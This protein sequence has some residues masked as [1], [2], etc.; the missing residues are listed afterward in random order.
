MEKWFEASWTSILAIF[1]TAGGIYMAII[2]FT[3]I[4]GKRSFSK[5][6]SFDFA[7]TVAVGSILATTI[8]SASVSLIHGIVGLAAVYI[9]QISA[10]ILRRFSWFQ[11]A[12]DNSPLLL[13]DGKKILHENLKKARVTEG[14][15]RSKLRE[16]NVLDLSQ[17]RA[18]VFETT[19]DISVLHTSNKD[20]ELEAW[21]TKDVINK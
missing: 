4:A 18:V 13:M 14:D 6:S 16:A 21:L 7:M 3:R 12:I 17:V 10:A 1:L 11:E 15:L 2:I 20:Q 19:G 5:M 9:L 8:L